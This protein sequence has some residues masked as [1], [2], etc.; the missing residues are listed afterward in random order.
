MRKI[1][2]TMVTQHPDHVSKPYF[3]DQAF[4]STRDESE[5]CYRSFA[6]IGATEYKW[7]WEGKL[8][9]ESVL[10][11]LFSDYYSYFK[12][13][14]LGRDRFL[15]F[16][17]P[18][19]NAETEFRIG[20]AF[21]SIAAANS[22]AKKVKLNS[23]ALFEVILPMTESADAMMAIP[24]AY[25]QMHNL[26]HEIYR[27]D[28]S[29]I[30]NLEVI[31]LF[32]QVE[33]ISHA[34]DII[35]EYV[36]KYKKKFGT[37]QTYIRPY[38]ARSDPA[39]NS[40]MIPTVLAVKIALSRFK[41]LEKELGI[42]MYPMLGAAALPFRGG[43]TPHTV[44]DFVKEFSGIRTTTIQSAFR[45]DYDLDDVKEA[46]Q[47]LEA[48]LPKGKAKT[49]S[50]ED[51]KAL[52][53]LISTFEKEYKKSVEPLAPI[54]NDVAKLLPKRRERVQ[55]VGL[56]GYSRGVGK[57]KLPRAIG[58][59]AAMYSL[60]LPPEIIGTGRGLRE[61]KKKGLLPILEQYYLNIRKDLLRAGRY[62]N[63]E[64]LAKRAKESATW[65]DLQKDVQA[66]EEY[67][68]KP[69]E[70]KTG[71]ELEHVVLT[72]VIANRLSDNLSVSE[73]IEEAA[74]MRK[75]MG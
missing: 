40:G 22:M 11:R 53:Q 69:L 67:L 51:E 64:L 59:T 45:F 15:T 60:G 39:I 58:F 7:D 23:P 46:I 65:A 56:F 74:R 9:D 73:F 68:G 54:I 25:A 61:A 31:P 26:T 20:R 41:A 42:T 34:D 62:V 4:I 14:Q 29:I 24:E 71:E 6:D 72:K 63:K 35:R 10:E 47:M 50:T 52:R 12:K 32:E 18:N 21:M 8:V 70:P 1:P 19:P 36:E 44:K 2:A 17:L 33:T 49:V 30:T 13:Q 38:M 28:T 27:F 66:I 43:L 16:R 37:T 57:V 75:S 55:H 48:L 5:E 3:L